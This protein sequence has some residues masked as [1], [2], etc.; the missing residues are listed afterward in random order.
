MHSPQWL[1]TYLALQGLLA[2]ALDALWHCC[3]APEPRAAF[4]ALQRRC[5]AAGLIRQDFLENRPCADVELARAV[6]QT[7]ATRL[8]LRLVLFGWCNGIELTRYKSSAHALEQVQSQ[9]EHIRYQHNMDNMELMQ[10]RAS[11]ADDGHD[12]IVNYNH[13]AAW[14]SDLLA[15][16]E[17]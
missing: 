10:H 5:E 6:Y 9:W 4:A 13:V 1:R 2:P 15:E 12:R 7:G 11:S 16:L 8:A 3:A 14:L 17:D